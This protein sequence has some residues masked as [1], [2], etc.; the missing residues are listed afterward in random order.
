MTPMATRAGVQPSRHSRRAHSRFKP[1]SAPPQPG[2]Q[3]RS[4][5]AL[6]ARQ[7]NLTAF[8]GVVLA[9]PG[10]PVIRGNPRP[11]ECRPAAGRGAASHQ[12]IPLMLAEPEVTSS[13]TTRRGQ[14]EALASLAAPHPVQSRRRS[15]VSADL[16]RLPARHP[17]RGQRNPVLTAQ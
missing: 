2:E 14:L 17:A 4:E 10:E 15:P 1:G 13:N 11:V 9:L 7:P 6:L 5:L 8:P 3:T 16:V 12:A